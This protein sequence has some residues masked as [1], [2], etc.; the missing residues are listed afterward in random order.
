[1]WGSHA[2][3][4]KGSP[5]SSS[6]QLHQRVA[7][8]STGVIALPHDIAS[9]PC[10]GLMQ[11][12]VRFGVEVAGSGPQHWYAWVKRSKQ[13]DRQQQWGVR[14]HEGGHGR[15]HIIMS[16][17]W[18]C[19][20][21]YVRCP[22]RMPCAMPCPM[23]PC[24]VSCV[25]ALRCCADG[26]AAPPSPGHSHSLPGC[27]CPLGCSLHSACL[28]LD[29]SQP[30]PPHRVCLDSALPPLPGHSSTSTA[31]WILPLPGHS[32]TSTPAWILPSLSPFLATATCAGCC[33]EPRAQHTAAESAAGGAEGH[34]RGGAGQCGGVGGHGLRRCCGAAA[35]R[36]PC[37]A[38]CSHAGGT[39]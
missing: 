26:V 3:S 2:S 29:D 7:Q 12:M 11:V 20:A 19:L 9:E 37:G 15:R 25:L 39:F 23:L 14:R 34:P 18:S 8:L 4:A 33:T 6:D 35:R 28:C 38:R 1:M 13:F 30:H 16:A 24:P 17:L 5:Q 21:S 31:A 22:C 36:G 10:K 32:S 27:P